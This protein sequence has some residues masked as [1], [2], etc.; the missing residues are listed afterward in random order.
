MDKLSKKDLKE[1]Y[2]NREV[3]GGIYLIKCS[4][5]SEAWLRSTT[6]IRGS[7]NRFTF[8]VAVDSPPEM[9]MT[10]AWKKFGKD[11]FTF[12]VLEEIKKKDSQTPDEFSDDIST[13]SDLWAEKQK[14]EN[15]EFYD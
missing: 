1:R 15:G 13:L 6:D 11:S 4:G 12:K 14:G 10:Q 9:C 2:K 7:F 8:S 5:N 3:V